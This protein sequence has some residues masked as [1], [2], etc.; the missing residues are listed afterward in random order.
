MALGKLAGGR[1]VPDLYEVFVFRLANTA[2][3]ALYNSNKRL[4]G[5]NQY[6]IKNARNVNTNSGNTVSSN[7]NLPITR[8]NVIVL[9]LPIGSLGG[10]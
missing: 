8:G 6:K 4:A 2:S 1:Y 7:N 9:V 5:L 3:D 10:P